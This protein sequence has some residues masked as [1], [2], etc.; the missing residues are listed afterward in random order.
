MKRRFFGVCDYGETWD[1]MRAFVDSARDDDEE[2]IWLLQHPPVYTL[3]RGGDG[4]HLLR[5]DGIPLIRSDRGGQITYHGP[6]QL[7]AY[8]LLNIRR[9]G[10][11]LRALVRCLEES[12][13]QLLAAHGVHGY[14][15]VGAP[16]VYVGGKKIAALGLRLRRGWTYHGVSL[17][18]RMDLRPFTNI[19][20][21]G[22]AGLEVTQTADCGM[23]ESA[24]T[25]APAWATRIEE[26]LLRR[27]VQI[28][29]V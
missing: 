16:G 12:V 15:D 28:F 29:R 26:A 14:G 9:R 27:A 23:T 5:D 19:N 18:V 24:E 13:I 6:G 25:L 10:L 7:V 11:A 8:P 21:C 17:N 1:N 3:G 20:P 2:E 22:Y 4:K